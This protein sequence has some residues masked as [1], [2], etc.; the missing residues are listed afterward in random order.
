[1][2]ALTGIRWSHRLLA[3]LQDP[4]LGELTQSQFTSHY[5]FGAAPGDND[6]VLA[7]L[8]DAVPAVIER[9]VGAG[10]VMLFNTTADDSWGDLPRRKSFVPLV[11]RL[12][13]YLSGGGVRRSFEVGDPVALPLADWQAGEKVEVVTPGGARM[14][15]TLADAGGRTLVR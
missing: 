6:T 3:P 9:S 12:L 5:R 13:N 15:P 4:L 14:T 11:D 7:W 2:A 1:L 8:D 10:K